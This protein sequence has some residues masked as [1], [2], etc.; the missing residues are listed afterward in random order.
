MHSIPV[1]LNFLQVHH[2]CKTRNT[3]NLFTCIHSVFFFFFFFF[4]CLFYL[5]FIYFF[6]IY[7][8]IFFF[9][10]FFFFFLD[11]MMVSGCL[12]HIVANT[13]LDIWQEGVGP[14]K[15]RYPMQQQLQHGG[16][17]NNRKIAP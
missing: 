7:L 5:F 3:C 9:F 10:F 1:P 8:F 12:V 4:F 6:F 13:L 14:K 11:C 2:K 16:V 15:A 17:I